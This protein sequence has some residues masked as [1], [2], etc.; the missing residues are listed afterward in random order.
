VF[1]VCWFFTGN[2]GHIYKAEVCGTRVSNFCL[3]R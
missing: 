2:P 3:E 1:F